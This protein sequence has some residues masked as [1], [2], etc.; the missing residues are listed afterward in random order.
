MNKVKHISVL[1]FA[2]GNSC[3]NAFAQAHAGLSACA[4]R[5]TPVDY[6]MT[7]PALCAVIGRLHFRVDQKTEVIIRGLALEPF[8]QFP[9]QWMVRRPSHSFQK[10]ML[11]MLHISSKALSRQLVTAMQCTKKFF[12]PI[13]QFLSPAGQLLSNVFG[14]K[15]YISN[16]VGHAIL[17]PDAE[18]PGIFAVRPPVISTR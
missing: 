17:H 11:D 15:S 18:Q 2:G 12:Q 6:G 14:Q 16:Q 10:T 7:N 13:Q 1:F 8:G 9:G 5:N 4:L 3:P